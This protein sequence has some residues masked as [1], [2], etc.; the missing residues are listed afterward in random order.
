MKEHGKRKGKTWEDAIVNSS[1]GTEE[2]NDWVQSE[3]AYY[4]TPI[5]PLP[6]N[7]QKVFKY[8]VWQLVI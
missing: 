6:F 3:D 7:I 8:L 2:G 4:A 1:W 5:G